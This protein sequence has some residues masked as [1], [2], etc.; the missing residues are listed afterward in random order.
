MGSV[1]PVPGHDV[2]ENADAEQICGKREAP[3][4]VLGWGWQAA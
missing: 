2:I 3:R 4:D 1:L